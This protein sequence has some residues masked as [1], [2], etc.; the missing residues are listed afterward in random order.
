MLEDLEKAIINLQSFSFAE[1][2]EKIVE[3]NAE[4]LLEIVRA[5]L[6]L[7]Y[8]GTGEFIYLISPGGEKNYN[9][10]PRTIDI[11]REYGLGIGAIV[12]HITLFDTGA[13]YS[14]LYISLESDG[15][16]EILSKDPK[17]PL[18]VAR[19]GEHLLEISPKGGE[20]FEEEILPIFQ[21]LIDEIL[22]I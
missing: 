8:E 6:E 11:K 13:F 18:L 22:E 3:I 14:S 19:S 15:N 2:T 1:H 4:D 20:V 12:D 5:Q 21:K 16:F 9:Y 7:G 10:S 17:Y